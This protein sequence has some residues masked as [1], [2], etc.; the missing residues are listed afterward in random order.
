MLHVVEPD[1]HATV[2]YLI[3]SHRLPGQVLRLAAALRADRPAAPIVIHHDPRGEPLDERALERLGA[4]QLVRSAQ[5]VVWGWASQLDALLRS[6]AWVC[7]R[8]DFD[9]LVVLSG[10]DYPARPLDEVERELADSP[11]DGYAPA[12]VVAV[13]A[14]TARAVDEFSARYHY[15]HHRIPPLRPRAR[16]AITAARPWLTLRDMPWGLLL[17]HRW[18]TPFSDAQPC[19]R[20]QDW[21]T[22]SRSAVAAVLAAAREEPHLVEHYRHTPHPTESFPH[23]VLHARPELRLSGDP[24]RFTSWSRPGSPHPD[25]LR[26]ADLEAIV[27]SGADFA[28]KLDITVDADILDALD[29]VAGRDLQAPL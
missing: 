8:V 13:P 14:L 17:G 4:V 9:W 24:R 5:P 6:L 18:P 12:D 1:R 3:L 2:A 20:G 23:T 21:L 7:E 29:R 25:V 10:Q 28:R 11:Y 19:R 16:R 22:L 15:R 27:A 26:L